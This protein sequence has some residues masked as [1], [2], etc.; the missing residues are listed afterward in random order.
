MANLAEATV[1]ALPEGGDPLG[2]AVAGFLSER[3]LAP[4]SHRVY[5]LALGR[6]TEHLGPATPLHKITHRALTRFMATCYSHL[7]PASWNRVAATLGSFFAYTTRQGWTP[8]SPAVGLERRH[9]RTSREDHDRTR[10]IAED[11]LADFLAASHPLRDKTLWWMLY[12]TAARAGEVLALNVADLDLPRR[13][14]VVIGK[15]GRAEVVG[16]ETKTARLLPRYLHGRR[17]GPLF[18]ADIA[19]APGRQPALADI[20][21]GTGRA[22]LSYR[23]AAEVFKVASGGRTLHQL[24]HSRLTHLAESGVQLPIL[25]GKSRHTSLTSLGVYAKPTFDAVAAATAALDPD[26]RR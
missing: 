15:G 2:Q 1:M 19:P 3:D 23:R 6:L 21:P 18:L 12:E 24:R 14:A 7:A 22:R 16:W 5:A 26:R 4:S 8:T 13:R 11:E 25:M 10:A 17:D 9:L 20:D